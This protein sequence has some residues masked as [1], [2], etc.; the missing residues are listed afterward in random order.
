MNTGAPEPNRPSRP[1]RATSADACAERIGS[2][3]RV[4]ERLGRGGT[5]VVYRVRDR[6]AARDI[7]LKQLH[8]ADGERGEQMLALFEHEYRTLAQ[9]SHPSVIEV[10]DYGID[11]AG[12]FYTMELLD[13]GDLSVEAPIPP[14]Q[15]CDLMMQVCSSLSL[16]HARHL[17]HRDVSPRNV[18]RTRSERA[19]LIDFGAMAA[20]GPCLHSAG[21]P[22][23]VAPE[24]VHRLK[25]D[26]RTDLFSLGATLYFALTGR[27]PFAAR[28]LAEL[29]EAFR[30]EPIAP[31]KLAADVP[32]ALDELVLALLR[33]DPARRP[34]SAFEVMQRLSAIAGVPRTESDDSY[35]AYLSAP[36]LVG[37]DSEQRRFRQ[38]LKRAQQSERSVLL[39]E[40]EPGMGRSRLLSVCALE[41]KTSGALV[42][43]LNGSAQRQEPFAGVQRL[44]QQ[45]GRV[46]PDGGR[47]QPEPRNA[48]PEL[49]AWFGA[50]TARQLLVIAI[51]DLDRIDQASLAWLVA[52]VDATSSSRLL[53][54]ATLA[55]ASDEQSQAALRVL[56]SHGAS[57]QLEALTSEQCEALLAETFSDAPHLALVSHR[58]HQL[59][60]GRPRETMALV[61]HLLNTGR[62]RF[63]DGSWVLPGELSPGDLPASAEDALRLRIARLPELTRSLLETHALSLEAA[64]TRDDYRA[65]CRPDDAPQLDAMLAELVDLGILTLHGESY[66]LSRLGVVRNLV[67]QLSPAAAVA[68]HRALADLCV[69]SGRPL[70]FEV[71]HR[72][73]CE[74]YEQALDRLAPVLQDQTNATSAADTSGLPRK[75]MANIVEHAHRAAVRMK[76]PR[77]E[78]NELS[79]VLTELSATTSVELF[80][81][82]APSW[83]RQVERDCGLEDYHALPSELSPA[84]R[85]QRALD[86][87]RARFDASAPADR[88]YE[89]DEAIK[90]LERYVT[91]GA[92]CAHNAS[93]TRLMG[94][95]AEKLAPFAATSPLLRTL[96]ERTIAHH[97]LSCGAK[98]E[99]A[100]V[101]Y[102]ATY[103]AMQGYADHELRY[104]DAIR[105]SLAYGLARL[106]VMLGY[107]TALE[108]IAV[109][110]RSPFFRPNALFLRRMLC[111][112]EGDI[113]GAERHRRQGEMLNA[114]TTARQIFPAPVTIELYAQVHAGDLAGVQQVAERAAK[115]AADAPGWAPL[116][117]AAQGH[118]QRM[119][120]ELQAAREAFERALA[121]ADPDRADPPPLLPAWISAV[122]GY[123]QV[124]TEQGELE[125]ACRFGSRAI[126]RAEQLEITEGTA[127]IRA[128]ALAEAKMGQHER[129]A[130]RLDRLIAAHSDRNAALFAPDLEARALVAIWAKDH[131]AARTFTKLA[132]RQLGQ[133]ATALQIARRGR[134]LDE[135]ARAGITLELATTGFESAVLSSSPRSSAP[136]IDARFIASLEALRDPATRSE[137]TLRLLC[138]AAHATA[139]RLYAMVDN[140]PVACATLGAAADDELDRFV[141]DYF[142]HQVEQAAMSTIFTVTEQATSAL[143]IAR[144]LGPAGQTQ[145]VALLKAANRDDY[146][147]AIALVAPDGA[148]QSAAFSVLVWAVSQR[149]V[150]LGSA[151]SSGTLRRTGR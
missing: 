44:A 28:T 35:R 120:G 126:E 24:V 54:V 133:Q 34:R 61:H 12:P 81:R 55:P 53:L 94:S 15:A 121:L 9:L 106:E 76:R 65:L 150:E 30:T 58:I 124:L 13:G 87:A 83:L 138:D 146:V 116:H 134:L 111:I 144:W 69:Q 145:R 96:H 2:R 75:A 132:T 26:A 18:R 68:H 62:V 86:G 105:Y 77:R 78:I 20:M 104:A 85:L 43:Q 84:V 122:A 73:H 67:A 135:A 21:T 79:R 136:A 10:Y 149:L 72:L 71:H 66:T 25:L 89:V 103:D 109:A 142:E 93:D 8:V 11:A 59:A 115:L 114:Q 98:L 37:R 38:A 118:F 7:A 123:I 110:E 60:A 48:P 3:Y 151:T 117:H 4:L 39:Y 19:K 51:D 99:R 70:L 119:R 23:F 14:R 141:Q 139:G 22:G 49:L 129:A 56:R 92:V 127:H 147:G 95:V 31:S 97:D 102:R 100:R 128:L 137:R 52:L 29:G 80:E 90:Y 47:L 113:E 17:L 140:A 16:L 33:I 63:V 36:T 46:L 148:V 88:V 112:F 125:Q 42:L 6:G 27:R 50:A 91:F 41:A 108:W 45:L 57:V 82:Y 1:P 107:D 64:L 32:P 40:A 130:Q 131:A 101:R 74:D 143:S 5:S